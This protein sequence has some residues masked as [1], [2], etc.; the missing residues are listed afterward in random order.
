[1][2]NW[3]TTSHKEVVLPYNTLIHKGTPTEMTDEQIIELCN[4]IEK[5]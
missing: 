1:L 4:E 2:K 5:L 3:H